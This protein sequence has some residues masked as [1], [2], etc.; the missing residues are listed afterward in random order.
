MRYTSDIND[1]ATLVATVG[2]RQSW[3]LFTL[4]WLFWFSS[5]ASFNDCPGGPT[6]PVLPV[7]PIGPAIFQP[8][9]KRTTNAKTNNSDSQI[10]YY[11]VNVF[12]CMSNCKECSSCLSSLSRMWW[13]F[14]IDKTHLF[15][16]LLYN[17]WSRYPIEL[18]LWSKKRNRF[19]LLWIQYN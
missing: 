11:I 14:V 15:C 2:I 8:Q 4:D 10:I 18:Q 1:C 17:D 16:F 9:L 12:F 3:W 6:G 13:V 7:G 19:C 5:P